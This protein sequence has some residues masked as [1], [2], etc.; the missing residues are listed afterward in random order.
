[1]LTN[2]QA[3]H[4]N[5]LPHSRFN[6]T[7]TRCLDMAVEHFRFM[8]KII[9]HAC[10]HEEIHYLAGFASQQERKARWLETTKCTTCFLATKQAEQAEAAVRDGAAI[11]HLDLP[12]LT[13]SDRQVAWAS[14]LRASRFCKL[15]AQPVTQKDGYQICVLITDAKWWIDHRALTEHELLKEAERR[16]VEMSVSASSDP[17]LTSPQA[18]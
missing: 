16:A 12:S 7:H 18:V 11:A 15:V 17:S 8:N 9:T 6:L 2:W 5:G 13:G 10:G 1:M 3:L 14:T 4:V